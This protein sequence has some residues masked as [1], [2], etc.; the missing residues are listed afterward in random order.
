MDSRYI[1]HKLEVTDM[2][3]ARMITGTN[4]WQ[5]W[6]EGTRNEEIRAKLGMS[7]MDE[8][9]RINRLW[10]WGHVRRMVEDKLPTRIMESVMEGKRSR[11]RPR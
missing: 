9:V 1:I 2:E 4:R 7:T 10:W 8:A 11:G 3:V 5:Q 6:Q